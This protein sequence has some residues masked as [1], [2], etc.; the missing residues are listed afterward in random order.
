MDFVGNRNRGDL[1]GKLGVR[2]G[3]MGRWNLEVMGWVGWTQRI[4]YFKAKQCSSLSTFPKKRFQWEGPLDLKHG[5]WCCGFF[6]MVINKPHVG[7][8]SDLQGWCCPL[9]PSLSPLWESLNSNALDSSLSLFSFSSSFWFIGFCFP[10]CSQS[11][12]S[13]DH[14]S[15][16]TDLP[17][18]EVEGE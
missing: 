6:P 15:S 10:L 14:D 9:T 8:Y 2:V 4:S 11:A 18:M 16:L 1:L 17:R 3:G 5:L 13:K 12:Q 7:P